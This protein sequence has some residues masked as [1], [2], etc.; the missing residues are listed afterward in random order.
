MA[1]KA[2]VLIFVMLV[3]GL[4]TIQA[5]V[6]IDRIVV[7]VNGR[8]L[9]ESDWEDALRF[10]AFLQ[11]RK[12]E[13]FTIQE[14][15]AALERLIDQELL[16]QQ[17]QGIQSIT[18]EQVKERIVQVR[19]Q[20]PGTTTEDGWRNALAAYGMTPADFEQRIQ[21]QMEML[22]FID[23][24]LRPAVHIETENIQ[25]YYREKLVP[26]LTKTGA[27]IAPLPAVSGNIEELLTQQRMDE[28][29]SAWLSNLRNQSQ[30][31]MAHAT[32]DTQLVPGGGTANGTASAK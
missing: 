11:G 13:T 14:Q 1:R 6:V 28:L 25:A 23:L 8:P 32:P 3:A 7:T 31:H 17:M 5:G 30:V 20:V 29:L 4:A 26:E 10:E 24:R 27:Q 12:L 19:S 16:R 22:Q 15:R 21:A 2:F 9:M 18:P